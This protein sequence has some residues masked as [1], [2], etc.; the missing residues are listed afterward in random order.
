MKGILS[1]HERMIDL[2]NRCLDLL[3]MV[4]AWWLIYSWQTGHMEQKTLVMMLVNVCAFQFLSTLLG[5]YSSWRGQSIRTQLTWLMVVLLISLLIT[6][7]FNHIV[8]RT[9][10][11][12]KLFLAVNQLSAL[13]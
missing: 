5:L 1:T 10:G 3:L 6:A 11:G 13:L 8:I 4:F 12:I 2:A 9:P 7:T